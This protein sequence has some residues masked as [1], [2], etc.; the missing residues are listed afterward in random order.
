MLVYRPVV[1]SKQKIFSWV[2]TDYRLARPI[3]SVTK[4]D[5]AA[6]KVIVEKE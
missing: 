4:T 1:I 6:I 2:K 5:I 3:I